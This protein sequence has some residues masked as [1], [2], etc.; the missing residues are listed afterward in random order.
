MF[1]NELTETDKK[2][3]SAIRNNPNQKR[4][5]IAEI[6]KV[7]W[8]TAT[9]SIDKLIEGNKGRANRYKGELE[10]IRIEWES[11]RKYCKETGISDVRDRY[12]N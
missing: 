7:A 5:K 9:T 3:L 12:R 4:T 10:D 6:A 1:L 8:T 2:I 11:K